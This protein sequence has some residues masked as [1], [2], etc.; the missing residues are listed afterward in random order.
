MTS[1]RLDHVGI[2][3]SDLDVAIEFFVMLGLEVDG[4]THIEGDFA[5]TV[6]GTPGVRSEIAM[7][8][9]PHDTGGTALELVAFEHPAPLPGQP[10]APSH[11]VGLRNVTFEVADL[12]G[13]VERL[14]GAGYRLVGGIGEYEGAWTMAHVRGPDG[15]IV[16]VAQQVG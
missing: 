8:R 11:T 13:V 3:V 7:L 4:R 2:T 10:D 14:T 9:L 16:S 12:P 15:V 6:L 1:L 5:D